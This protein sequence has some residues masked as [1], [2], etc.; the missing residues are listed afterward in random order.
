MLQ[1]G[2]GG[3]KVFSSDVIYERPY[4]TSNLVSLNL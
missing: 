3:Q 4:M 1:E 2:G